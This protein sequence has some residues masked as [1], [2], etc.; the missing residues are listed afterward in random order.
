MGFQNAT[1]EPSTRRVDE[2]CRS[3]LCRDL[4]VLFATLCLLALGMIR[5]TAWAVT[6]IGPGTMVFHLQFVFPF[7]LCFCRIVCR[8]LHPSL[9]QRASRNLRGLN[10][11][12]EL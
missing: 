12:E 3:R 6:L 11:I 10:P 5:R 8:L 2:S 1:P 7:L 9:L 4:S